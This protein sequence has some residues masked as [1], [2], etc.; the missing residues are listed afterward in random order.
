MTKH[1]TK[2]VFW[3]VLRTAVTMKIDVHGLVFKCK[4][5]LGEHGL[6]VHHNVNII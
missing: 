5:H 6:E 4:S 3:D 2:G 1:L